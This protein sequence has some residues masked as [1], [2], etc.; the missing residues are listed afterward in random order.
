MSVIY[1][2][3]NFGL[4]TNGNFETGTNLYFPTGA[5]YPEGYKGSYS[6]ENT[7]DPQWNGNERVSVDTTKYYT[8][9]FVAK[10]IKRSVP[11]N[12]LGSG[13]IGFACYDQLDNFV[14]LRNCGGVGDTTLT[15][16]C[17]PGD[18]YIY[19]ASNSGW[20]VATDVYYYRNILLF[21]A[22]HPY[23]ST[24]WKYSRIGFGDYNLYYNEIVDISG[25]G[26]EYRLKL[27]SDGT[28]DTTMPNIGHSLPVGTPVSRGAAGGTYNYV[29]V[30]NFPETWTKYQTAPFTGESRNS[31]LPFRNATKFIRF[32][33]LTN[34]GQGA[35]TTKPTYLLDNILLIESPNNRVFNL[36]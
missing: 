21:P 36:P 24:P 28:A 15:R 20:T 10:T 34:Y 32:L 19:I 16:A 17:N 33:S 4:F 6:L 11:S 3:S 35:E 31:Q 9:S 1:N 30:T 7:G 12:N 5:V 8:Y 25:N 26:T 29:F 13:Y 22:T 14:D 23:Y 27:S 2:R 18:Q